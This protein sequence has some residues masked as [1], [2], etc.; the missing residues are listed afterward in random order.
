LF[1]SYEEGDVYD[2]KSGWRKLGEWFYP[3]VIEFDD[4]VAWQVRSPFW[5]DKLFYSH[6]NPE[7]IF[8]ADT[9]II[10]CL[11]SVLGDPVCLYSFL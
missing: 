8:F 5:K 7:F 1:P 11:I 4:D 6:N 10:F 3:E 2:K 9:I